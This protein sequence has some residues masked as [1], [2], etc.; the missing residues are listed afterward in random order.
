MASFPPQ[1]ATFAIIDNV[2]AATL[3]KEAPGL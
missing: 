2:I 1:A 3:P